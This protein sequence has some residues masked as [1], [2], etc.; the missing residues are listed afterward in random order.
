MKWKDV[1]EIKKI[2]QKYE[3]TEKDWNKVGGK[4]GGGYNE[5]EKNLEKDGSQECKRENKYRRRKE[6]TNMKD[7]VKRMNTYYSMNRQYRG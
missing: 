6:K 4:D 5:G 3:E 1:E 2:G 7:T